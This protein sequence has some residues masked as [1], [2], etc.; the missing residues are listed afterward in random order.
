VSIHRLRVSLDHVEPPIWR[1]IEVK[2]DWPLDCVADAVRNS[3]GWSFD[4][5]YKFTIKRR[6]Y[7]THNHWVRFDPE[8]EFEEKQRQIRKQKLGPRQYQRAMEQLFDWYKSLPKPDDTEEDAIPFLSELVGRA[9]SKFTFVFDFGDWWRHTIRVEKI[10]P[11]SPDTA[12]PR[13][14]DG[15]GANPLEDCGG[16]WNLM[17][18]FDAVKYPERPRNET[19]KHIVEEWGGEDWEFMRFSVDEANQRLRG[20][21]SATA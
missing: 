11:A 4:H 15:T 10:E 7:G 5:G 8:L 13:C 3:F 1:R 14:V 6:D 20:V 21:F 2:S 9:G 16:P 17:A 12:Y 19:I 18:V